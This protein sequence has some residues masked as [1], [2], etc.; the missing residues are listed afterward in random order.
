MQQ[1]ETYLLTY[2][3]VSE[4]QQ[5]QR[6]RNVNLPTHRCRHCRLQCQLMSIHG[7][8]LS[9]QS[10][11]KVSGYCSIVQVP[12]WAGTTTDDCI[13]VGIWGPQISGNS[14]SGEHRWFLALEIWSDVFRAF[15]ALTLL[16]GRQEGHPA[17]TNWVVGYWRGYLTG[18]RCRLAQ[19][20]PLRLTVSCFSKIQIGLSFLVP[21]HLVSPGKS[22]VKRVCVCVC[23]CVC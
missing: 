7:C 6:A 10:L 11:M 1:S 4:T 3:R 19:R 17:C 2:L 14:S 9:S 12:E 13:L 18:A 23:V 21:A 15:S 22:A 5:V 8:Q 16:V 20:M